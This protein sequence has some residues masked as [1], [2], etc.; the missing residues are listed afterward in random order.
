VQY[1]KILI[2]ISARGVYT[3]GRGRGVGW[4]NG[5]SAREAVVIRW[6]KG[7][8]VAAGGLGLL[9][10]CAQAPAPAKHVV[11]LEG[12]GYAPAAIH[13]APGD[14]VVWVNADVVP[15]TATAGDGAFDSGS[16]GAGASWKWVA[17]GRGRHAYRCTFHPTMVGE[18]VVD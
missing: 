16:I 11:R 6:R 7:V 4:G 14:T 13:V 2:D 12:F 8:R 17:E 15:H 10:A 5:P 18:L 3:V 9:A 1:V